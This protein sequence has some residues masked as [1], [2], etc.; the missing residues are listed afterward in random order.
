MEEDTEDSK[1]AEELTEYVSDP[2]PQTLGPLANRSPSVLRQA[3]LEAYRSSPHWRIA[4]HL[5]MAWANRIGKVGAPPDFTRAAYFA[6]VSCRLSDEHPWARFARATIYWERRLTYLVLD[7]ANRAT[8]QIGRLGDPSQQEFLVAQLDS[9][10][11]CALAYEGQVAEA[12]QICESIASRNFTPT[13]EACLQCFISTRPSEPH[14][15]HRAAILSAR[16]SAIFG[17][18]PM[19]LLTRAL[20]TALLRALLSRAD[21]DA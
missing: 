18:R 9:L 7:D 3:L 19:R 6:H 10:R 1:L 17:N 16:H 14:L 11:A 2:C 8:E 20:Q 15:H 5:T 13:S 21:C 4:Q 12:I